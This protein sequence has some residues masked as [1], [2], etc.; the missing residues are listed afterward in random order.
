MTVDTS[1]PQTAVGVL[2]AHLQRLDRSPQ[3]DYLSAIIHT[4]ENHPRSQQRAI[5]PSEVGEP[6][7]RKLGYKLLGVPERPQQPAWKPTVGTATHAWLEGVF[8]AANLRGIAALEDHERWMVETRLIVAY[9][10]ELEPLVGTPW[11]QGSCDLY[12]RVTGR[13]IDHKAVGTA[14]L[15]RC[16]TKGPGET[17]R[18]QAH[19]YGLGWVLRGHPVTEV[20]VSFLPRDGQL[21]DAVW[22]SEPFDRAVAEQAV[23]RLRGLAVTVSALGAAAPTVLPTAESYCTFCP[24]YKPNGDDLTVGCPGHEGVGAQRVGSQLDGLL[25]GA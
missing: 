6:C 2:P 18:T 5:G 13:V 25:G 10:P 7:A 19:L 12:D 15:R 3:A 4:I 17:Y 1:S 11:L 14:A 9:L 16:R 21:S 20:V 8:D 24:F 22:W 23:E